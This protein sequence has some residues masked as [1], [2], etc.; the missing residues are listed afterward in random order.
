MLS[1]GEASLEAGDYETSLQK[2][3]TALKMRR[4][5]KRALELK[6]RAGE[7][8]RPAASPLWWP[9]SSRKAGYRQTLKIGDAEYGFVWIPA[10]E[11]DMGSPKSEEMRRYDETLHHVVLTRGFWMLETPTTQTLYREIM[12]GNPS[13]FK[14]NNLPVERVSM[15][16]AAAFCEELRM[17]LPKGLRASLPTEAQWE[18]ACRAGTT[19]PYSFGNALNGDK[20]NCDGNY[21]YGTESKGKRVGET[22][23]VKSYEPNAWGLYDMHGNVWE[24]AL[25]YYGDYPTG[26]V[27]DPT[28]PESASY[29]VLRGGSWDYD[30]RLCR[31][32]VRRG[33]SPDSR[34]INLGFRFLLSCD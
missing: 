13:K 27:I 12:E 28:G 3:K 25:D 24:W 4:N 10:G 17:R 14:G 29:R 11:F 5:D 8:L 7:A 33:F 34:S 2:A 6:K 31:S 9:S 1:V 20:A 32:A 18:Y 16:D 30:A 15:D 22:T 26:T 21:P 19:T 23:P